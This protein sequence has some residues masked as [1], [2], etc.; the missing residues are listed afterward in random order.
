MCR[1]HGCDPWSR[2]I[3]HAATTEAREP[4]GPRSAARQATTVRRPRTTAKS[5][6]RLQQREKARAKATVGSQK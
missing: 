5:S 6:P 2:K 4:R 3:P 1:A